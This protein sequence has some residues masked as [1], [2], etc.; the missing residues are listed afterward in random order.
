[1]GKLVQFQHTHNLR[2]KVVDH[3]LSVSQIITEPNIEL[4]QHSV[5]SIHIEISARFL[6]WQLGLGYGFRIHF[7]P[8][9]EINPSTQIQRKVSKMQWLT[10]CYFYIC[11]TKHYHKICWQIVMYDN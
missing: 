6:I 2:K 1:M 11:L 3:K 5:H 10:Q 4:D 8:K 7:S 9:A